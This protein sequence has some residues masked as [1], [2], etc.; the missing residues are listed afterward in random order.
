MELNEKQFITGFNS[1]YLLA[2][3]EPQMLTNLLEQIR[4]INSYI[5]GM[6]FGRKEFELNKIRGQL[7]ELEQ[8]RQKSKRDKQRDK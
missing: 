6:T 2:E 4:P 7:N 8:I 3:F 1:G 5:S